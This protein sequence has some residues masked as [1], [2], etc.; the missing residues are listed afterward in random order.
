MFV[1]LLQAHVGKSLNKGA[2]KAYLK[3]KV[4]LFFWHQDS[5]TFMQYLNEVFNPFKY[6][7]QKII[8][9]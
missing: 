7:K 4:V 9:H 2:Q 6:R 8:H 3:G 1:F 5:Q